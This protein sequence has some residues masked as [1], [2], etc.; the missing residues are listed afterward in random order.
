[1]RGLSRSG[2]REGE[3]EITVSNRLVF[4][5][6]HLSPF[7]TFIVSFQE[8][9]QW[10]EMLCR[11]CGLAREDETAHLPGWFNVLPVLRPLE[12]S[13]R[14]NIYGRYGPRR[15]RSLPCLSRNAFF[16]AF[17]SG[18]LHID[19]AL[20]SA[21]SG[22][23]TCSLNYYETFVMQGRGPG[24]RLDLRG[25]AFVPIRREPQLH[26]N[27]GECFSKKYSSYTSLDNG[28][29]CVLLIL[30]SRFPQ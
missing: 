30:W 1:M 22:E 5:L 20:R 27:H 11:A 28:S 18:S 17:L 16:Y 7:C 15:A 21:S 9:E 2:F 29:R 25:P 4:T 10:V 8:M 19:A 23:I 3:R 12:S 26:S 6:G 13:R 14:S 24:Q